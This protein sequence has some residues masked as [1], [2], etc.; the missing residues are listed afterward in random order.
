MT[1]SNIR[2]IWNKKTHQNTRENK[3]PKNF[4]QAT[5]FSIKMNRYSF[6][7]LLNIF[8]WMAYSNCAA[9]Y[10][11]IW[12]L[13]PDT[14]TYRKENIANKTAQIYIGC[15]VIFLILAI[16]SLLAAHFFTVLLWWSS[17][18]KNAVKEM[19][20]LLAMDEWK[21]H[22][23]QIKNRSL[24]QRTIQAVRLLIRLDN[25]RIG[26]EKSRTK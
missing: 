21:K 25:A 12:S 13:D 5:K 11:Q 19:N 15:A 4:R 23:N 8:A 6:K 17:D 1:V 16:V 22:T 9:T 20:E 24:W 3:Y 26:G 7:I 2:Q 14:Q 10:F 18:E